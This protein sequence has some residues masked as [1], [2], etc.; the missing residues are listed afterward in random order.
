MSEPWRRPRVLATDLDGTLVR[1][2]GSVSPRSRKALAAAERG[3]I[4]VIFVSARPPRWLDE[5]TGLVASHGL[6]ICANGAIRYDV[7][8]RRVLSTTPLAAE[9]VVAVAGALRTGLPGTVFAAESETGFV[10]EP[11]YLERHPLRRDPPTGL[12]ETL[13][14]PLPAK[15]LARN[16]AYGPEEYVEL[17]TSLV[18][19]LVEI[20]V[21]GATGLLE[22][23]AKGVTKASALRAWCDSNGIDSTDVWA[24]GDMPNDL[25]MLAWA[26]RAF[27]VANA[28]A[29]VQSMADSVSAS[30]DDDGV[31][32]VL[33]LALSLPADSERVSLHPE[34]GSI[35]P[36]DPT[37]R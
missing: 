20:H 26:G 5:L 18:G 1:S 35:N 9:T 11:D 37:L 19:H 31:A 4:A 30:N 33:E 32:Q 21:S 6:A 27:A 24:A 34:G 15:L 10:K 12:I 29:D 13:L 14:D 28:H 2:D 22:M 25:P 7:G 36:K 8:A 16:E 3:G 23:S 17:A